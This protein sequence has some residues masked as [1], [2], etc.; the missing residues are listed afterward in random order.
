[1]YIQNNLLGINSINNNKR[2]M[3]RLEKSIN[4]LSSGHRINVA[5][6]DAAGSSISEKMKGQI[7]GLKMASR[8]ALDAYSLMETRDGA[9]DEVHHMMQRMR[10]L[11]IQSLNDTL[12]DEDREKLQKE[13][14][15]LQIAIAKFTK[16][17][18]W[19]T[20]PIFEAHESSF[21]TFEGNQ[22]FNQL[23]K[24]VDG[25]NNDLEVSVDGKITNIV[26]DEGYYTIGEIADIIDDKLI[27]M[28]PN[29]IINLTEN[30]CISIQSENSSDIDY[31]KGGLSFLFYEYHI[32]TPPGMIIGV[33]EF[34]E[35]G[36][37][38]IIPG[39]NDKLKFYVGA[40]KEYT[41]NFQPKDGGYSID[42]LINIIN[43]QLVGQGEND[44]KA[45]KY[46]NKHI[47]LHSDK[48]VI[49]GLS[50]NM[51]KIDGITSVLYDNAKY[52]SVS[53]TQAS[54]TGGKDLSDGITITEGENDT[55]R[56]KINDETELRTI[57]LLGEDETKKHYTL[58][59]LLEKINAEIE[60]KDLNITAKESGN[61]L[62][63]ISNYYGSNSRVQLDPTSNAYEDLFVG[64]EEIIL[65][66]MVIEGAE[67]SATI[68]GRYVLGEV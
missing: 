33:T 59:Q 31:I 2:N 7:R 67:T 42:E 16:E 45:I 9:L 63:L 50:G 20:K 66:P 8:N 54:V 25:L 55:L 61:R 35:N 26:L 15:A 37:L 11:T 43:E 10:E 56:L 48:Y 47:A 52:G 17:S 53:K 1:M 64:E 5:A 40:N 14:R 44:V 68:T 65:E 57:E 18:E 30:N 22:K 51:I 6:D 29:L 46:S 38:K 27:K 34:Q 19:N 3:R 58:Y 4:K 39:S 32:G 24:I 23:V 41:I 62:E 60:K 13:F 21:Y 49:T 12:T 36:R 28:A